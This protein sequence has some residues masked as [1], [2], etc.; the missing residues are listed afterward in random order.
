MHQQYKKV[1]D[2]IV[3]P[4]D[5]SVTFVSQQFVCV[6]SFMDVATFHPGETAINEHTTGLNHICIKEMQH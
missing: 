2:L 1:A 4:V 3:I 6:L 5:F